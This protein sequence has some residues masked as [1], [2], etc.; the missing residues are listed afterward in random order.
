MD[1]S[2]LVVV[3]L[4]VLLGCPAD[5]ESDTVADTAETESPGSTGT[6]TG[7]G[8]MGESESTAAETG[9]A[10]P[11]CPAQSNVAVSVVVQSD[12]LTT[13]REA[14]PEGGSISLELSCTVGM[15]DPSG[16]SLALTCLG[17]PDQPDSAWSVV[18][19][20]VPAL[21]VAE[22]DEVQMVLDNWWAFE[23]GGGS[24]LR[25]DQGGAP[26]LLAYTESYGGG[27]SGLCGPGEL[28]GEADLEGL[29]APLGLAIERATCEPRDR[30]RLDFEVDGQ[31]TTLHGGQEADLGNSGWTAA[32]PD[33]TC[34]SA[35]DDPSGGF[36][37]SWSVE[38]Y[39]WKAGA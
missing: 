29:F 39:A 20:G 26:F 13:A 3:G 2:K 31:A 4:V 37:D 28:H 5:E 24:M 25:L 14:E 22:S 36:Y 7:S 15:A 30:L 8:G 33:A 17:A 32:A 11:E 19:E 6:G 35:D 12:V 21:P 38:L 16:G 9:E 18:L 1:Y 23:V 10:L 27:D 34:V